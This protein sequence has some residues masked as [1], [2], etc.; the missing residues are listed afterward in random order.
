VLFN[1]HH[2]LI[3]FKLPDPG[4]GG[5]WKIEVD[6]SFDDGEPP[7]DAPPPGETYPLQGRSLALLRQNSADGS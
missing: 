5:S 3:D 1:A 7:P 4:P 2:D 6:T